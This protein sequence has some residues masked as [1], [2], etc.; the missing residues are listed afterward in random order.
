ME[1]ASCNLKPWSWPKCIVLAPQMLKEGERDKCNIVYI[2]LCIQLSYVNQR[3]VLGYMA[4]FSLGSCLD[5]YT[6]T[7]SSLSL[8]S[9]I[10]SL[11]GVL[12]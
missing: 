7:L 8:R 11:S 2:W 3:A 4:V 10:G 12:A 6:G 9:E 1:T 5:S